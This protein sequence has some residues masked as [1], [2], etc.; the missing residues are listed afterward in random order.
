MG[1]KIRRMDAIDQRTRTLSAATA[2]TTGINYVAGANYVATRNYFVAN[3]RSKGL[4]F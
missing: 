3:S 4:I 2:D 1:P